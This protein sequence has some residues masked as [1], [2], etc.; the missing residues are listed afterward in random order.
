[1][2]FSINALVLV[3][4]VL[5]PV[6][7]GQQPAVDAADQQT[8]SGDALDQ[9][10][11]LKFLN[12]PDASYDTLVN[13][14]RLQSRAAGRIVGHVRGHD[15]VLGTPDDNLLDDVA[16]LDAIRYVGP[17]TIEALNA[18]VRSHYQHHDLTVE[19]VDLGA[20]V[21]LRMVDIANTAT[22]Q[23]LDDDVGLDARA[24][25][26]IVAARPLADIQALAAVSYIGKTALTKL[27]DYAITHPST[28]T[29]PPPPVVIPA[30]EVPIPYV[31]QWINDYRAPTG[32][33]TRLNLNRDGSYDATVAGA[34]ETGVFFG[35][36]VLP[37]GGGIALRLVSSTG[38]EWQA[39]LTLYTGT[40]AETV[41][42]GHADTL[43]A[44]LGTDGEDACGSGGGGYL[45][46]DSNAE[47]LYCACPDNMSW[48]PS[49][50]GCVQ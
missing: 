9:D 34:A 27:R 14:V 5:L 23:L 45:D 28:A 2:H 20:D 39:T 19:G 1:M 41:R 50:G 31:L 43:V 24:A 3:P 44:T 12:G 35:P 40:S 30:A 38:A 32:Y 18:Y 36:R 16:E 47:G 29:D 11:I 7:C 48:I 42:D 33:L 22:S 13:D 37:A 25:R 17:A 21:A 26:A 8:T 4:L 46:D 6:A 15:R 49:Q 10:S